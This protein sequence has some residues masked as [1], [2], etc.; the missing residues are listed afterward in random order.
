M[1]KLKKKL[2]TGRQ[3]AARRINIEIARRSKKKNAKRTRFNH[4]VAGK[5]KKI[6]VMIEKKRRRR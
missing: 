2:I 3:K 6:S 1:P 4:A 5:S